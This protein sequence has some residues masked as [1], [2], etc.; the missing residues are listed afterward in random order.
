MRI[1]NMMSVLY[2]YTYMLFQIIH[3]WRLFYKL[4]RDS[5]IIKCKSDYVQ[6][7]SV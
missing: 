6:G 7:S 2:L 1:W 3:I 4:V 5:S